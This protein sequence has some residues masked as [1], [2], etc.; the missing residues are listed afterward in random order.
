M[1]TSQPPD[2]WWVTSCR[3]RCFR[4]SPRIGSHFCWASSL[5]WPPSILAHFGS[6]FGREWRWR[7]DRYEDLLRG[8]VTSIDTGGRFESEIAVF[9]IGLTMWLVGYS[10]AWMLFRHGWIFWSLA[11]PGAI[12]L[13]TLALERERPTWPALLY[14]GLALA[15]AA[16]HT[17][18]SR[19]AFWRS[20]AIA[21]RLHS[22]ADRS[23]RHV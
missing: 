6:S 9:A 20:R 14:L 16:A 5:L 10:A 7:L 21:S 22:V 12:L 13:V 23:Y 17:A 1:A 19:S 18:V 11:L 2:I 3:K 8:F 15:M 4:T